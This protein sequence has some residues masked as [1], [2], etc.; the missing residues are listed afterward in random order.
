MLG[1]VTPDVHASPSLDLSSFVIHKDSHGVTPDVQANPSLD[2]SSYVIH[3]GSHA[4]KCD[5]RCSG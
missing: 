2:W 4:R 3:K 5:T 1:S